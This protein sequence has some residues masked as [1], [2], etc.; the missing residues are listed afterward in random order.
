MRYA[1]SNLFWYNFL[2]IIG[3]GIAAFSIYKKKHLTELSTWIVFYLFATSIT[4]LGEFTVLGFFSSYAY[5]PGVFSDPWAENLLGHLILNSTLWPGMAILVVAYSLDYKWIILISA[6]NVLIEYLFVQFGMYEQHWWKYY[7]TA[8]T[9]VLFLTIAKKWFSIINRE[10]HGISRFITLYLVAVVIIHISFPL[11][12]LLDKQYYSVH[13]TENL[14]RSSIIFILSYHLIETFIIV[15]FSYFDTRYWKA[16]PF[17]ISS[18][19]QT[20]LAS[21][22]ILIFKDEW[23]LFY[24]IIIYAI[25]ITVII[26]V[27]KH[28]LKPRINK[29]LK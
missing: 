29:K 24:T 2:A 4:W 11:L 21:R 16:V 9:V 6:V 17:V 14:Y 28:T 7:M 23:N 18:L 12:L 1:M 10:R 19:G 15:I 25:S 3:I 27:E 20:F 22:G 5:K 13:L 8:V 26:L